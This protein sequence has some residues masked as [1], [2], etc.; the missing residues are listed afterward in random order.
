MENKN[1][2]LGNQ[3]NNLKNKYQLL[4]VEMVIQIHKNSEV[5]VTKFFACFYF[6]ANWRPIIAT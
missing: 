4:E 1:D 3:I 2:A 5:S 6:R